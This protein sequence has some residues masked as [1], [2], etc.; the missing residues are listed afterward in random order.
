[1]VRGIM[2]ADNRVMA[3]EVLRGN[4]LV[5]LSIEEAGHGL[6]DGIFGMFLGKVGYKQLANFTRQLSTMMTAGLALTDALSLLSSQSE[7]QVAMHKIIEHCLN[8]VRGGQSLATALGKYS[9]EFGEAYVA[10]IA[11]GEQGGVLEDVLARLANTMEQE[12]EFR[13]K[14]KGAMIYP[15]VVIFGI[16]G[17]V[18]VLLVFVIPK[19]TGLY[20]DFGAKMPAMTQ[21]VI[22]LSGLVIKLW[23][24]FPL[25]PIALLIF[26]KMVN[27]RPQWKYQKDNLF[28]KIPLMGELSKISMV[29]DICRTL[30][31]LLSA[32]V[33]L[34]EALQ[35]VVKVADNQVYQQAL[36]RIS[37]RVE[38]GFSLS[39]CFAETEVF[40]MI[41]NQMIATGEATGKLDEVLLRVADYFSK[42]SES[43]VKGLTSAIEP[44]IMVMLG[45][46][47]G[48][49]VISVIMPIYDLTSK[50]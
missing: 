13:S 28:L 39:D 22:D 14:V 1:M 47:V 24:L 35:I 30:S 21:F 38:K 3:L 18:F 29:A 43:L 7:G 17:V 5:P 34:T 20:K 19:M 27:T 11:A 25:I 31:M 10:S 4:K 32:G 48:F 16:I 50:F 12:Q 49:L 44:L 15:A 41:V 45:G 9:D 40:P 42:E 6:F 26:L 33:P 37:S 36:I 23:F 2:E 8:T 46:V